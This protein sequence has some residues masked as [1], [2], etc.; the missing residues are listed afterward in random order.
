M[1]R[2]IAPGL[3]AACCAVLGLASPAAA[4]VD[5]ET[6]RDPAGAR[7]TVVRIESTRGELCS[8]VVIGRRAVLTAAHCVLGG[9]RFSVH[10]L[11]P[12]FQARRHAVARIIVHP[13][14]VP[15]TTPR[16]QP[17]TDL[18]VIR[19]AEPLPDDL[20]AVAI[21]GGIWTGETITIAGYGLATERRKGSA[22]T[23]RHVRL[24]SA[25]TYTS[26][27]SVTVAVDETRHGQTAGGGA[28]RGDSGGPALRGGAG[29]RDLA[30]IVSW[31]S[32][33]LGARVKT[34][35]GGFTSITPVADH[36]RWISGAAEAGPDDAR[37]TPGGA[38]SAPPVVSGG[39]AIIR[40]P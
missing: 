6:A 10:S 40:E 8:G 2:T 12:S 17:G 32:G 36:A 39:N 1:K 37:R 19:L 29:S 18:A 4:I 35:C 13:T 25:G 9:G 20:S 24:V 3:L 22:R 23:L 15:G 28:C 14:F 27:N 31:S 26:A 34:V 30:G 11:S 7:S 21:G 5:G 33:P 16:T 38:M